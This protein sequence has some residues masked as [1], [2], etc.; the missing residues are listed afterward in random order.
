MLAVHYCILAIV[1]P[2]GHSC[3]QITNSCTLSALQSLVYKYLGC[4][5]AE[6]TPSAVLSPPALHHFHHLMYVK[7]AVMALDYKE[8]A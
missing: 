6:I 8:C 7:P 5:L 1:L 4:P 3:D 2:L